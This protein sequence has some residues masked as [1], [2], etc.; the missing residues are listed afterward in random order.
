[1]YLIIDS[2]FALCYIN[3]VVVIIET[4]SVYS[5]VRTG[6]SK[7]RLRFVFEG[8]REKYGSHNNYYRRQIHLER[9]TK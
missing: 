3:Y 5:V 2:E 4:E 1:M 8:A 6:S 7:N 9:H